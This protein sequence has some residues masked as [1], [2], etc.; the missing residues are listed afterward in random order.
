MKCTW[1]TRSKHMNRNTTFQYQK[2]SISRGNFCRAL[3]VQRK[4]KVI[5]ILESTQK[6]GDSDIETSQLENRTLL[7]SN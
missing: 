7:E 5:S 1:S 2:K 4:K 3:F 6:Y